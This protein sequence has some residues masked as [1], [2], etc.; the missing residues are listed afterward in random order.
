MVFQCINIRQVPWEGFGRGFQHL[1]RNLANVNA[2][3]TMF[4]PYISFSTDRSKAVPLLQVFFVRM[5]EKPL[6]FF[7]FF[8][9]FFF[10]QSSSFASSGRLYFV[11]MVFPGYLHFFFRS[12]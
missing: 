10:C 9:C 7:G 4:D 8:F 3:K 6:V 2:L 5:S 12:P 11:T 1:P